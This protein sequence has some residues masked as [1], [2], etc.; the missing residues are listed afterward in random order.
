MQIVLREYESRVVALSEEQVAALSY[1]PSAV[2]GVRPTSEAGRYELKAGSQV[3][4]A[5]LQADLGIVIQPKVSIQTL[6]A[7]VAATY[8]PGRKFLREE[9]QGYTTVE[10]LFEFI[11]C[12]FVKSLEELLIRGLL[13]GYRPVTDNPPA[14]RGR[15][16]L[17]QTMHRRPGLH[18]RHW[19]CYSRFTPDVNENRILKWAAYCLQYHRYADAGLSGRLQRICRNMGDV[20]VDLG[21]RR[22]FDRLSFH[23][24]NESYRP[25]LD[26][27][28]LLLD[29]LGFSGSAG[30]SPFFGYLIDMERLFE[31]YVISVLEQGARE[32]GQRLG[33]HDR[34]YVDRESRFKV[35]P[36]MTIYA[37]GRPLLVVDAKYKLESDRHDIYQMIA[38][39]HALDIP[40]AVLVY[41]SSQTTP[42]GRATVKGPGQLEV[43]QLPLDLRG[44]SAQLA[45]Q[46]RELA[47]AVRRLLAA[48][49]ASG[50]LVHRFHRLP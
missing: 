11:V 28:R 17:A 1:F 50:S 15:L 29:H 36:D 21:A 40:R 5:T 9:P 46:G 47:E 25:A 27:A 22:L 7:L 19:C 8:D 30:D 2:V 18:D 12:M 45:E 34:T 35:I 41:P 3:G 16:L 24:L 6:F 31:R 4:F 43:H 42:E 33:A 10:A 20:T 39:C 26:L 37:D 49:E 14:I 32:W 13:R 38:Y 23:R 48:E 44:G